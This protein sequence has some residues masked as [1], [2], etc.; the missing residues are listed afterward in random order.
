[1]YASTYASAD[2]GL[3][4]RSGPKVVEKLSSVAHVLHTNVPGSSGLTQPDS[5]TA[6]RNP[7]SLEELREAVTA[8]LDDH[9]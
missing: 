1:M 8:A 9:R 7:F 2:I 5:G 4:E 3:L 6:L